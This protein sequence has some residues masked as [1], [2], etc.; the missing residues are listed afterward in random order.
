MKKLYTILKS[1]DDL[2]IFLAFHLKKN[3]M[4]KIRFPRSI[5]I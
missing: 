5:F 1:G 3:N 4:T 2:H